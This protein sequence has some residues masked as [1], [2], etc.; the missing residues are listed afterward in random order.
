MLSYCWNTTTDHDA[1]PHT[2]Y[3]TYNLWKLTSLLIYATVAIDV[4][5]AVVDTVMVMFAMTVAYENTS[6]IVHFKYTKH[7]S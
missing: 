3:H 2:Q 1:Q 5:A 6:N 7:R 4:V